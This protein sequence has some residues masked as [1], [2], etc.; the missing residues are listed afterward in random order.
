MFCDQKWFPS[1][2]SE[3]PDPSTA[4]SAV[5]TR[6]LAADSAHIIWYLLLRCPP[7]RCW[8]TTSS[9]LKNLRGRGFLSYRVDGY[10]NVPVGKTGCETP[11]ALNYDV[12]WIAHFQTIII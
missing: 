5:I 11:F 12:F 10:L 1:L 2:M 4:Q 3:R 9:V 6:S 8:T 7:L